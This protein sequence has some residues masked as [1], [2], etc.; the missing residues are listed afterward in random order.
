MSFVSGMASRHDDLRGFDM[1][2]TLGRTSTG[3]WTTEGAWE[4]IVF[5]AMMSRGMV[6]R[7]RLTNL[8]RGSLDKMAGIDWLLSRPDGTQTG[9]A[10]RT[11]WGTDYGTF[12]VR[13]RTE[14][15]SMSEATKRIMS[16][17]SGVGV[18]PGLTGQAYV[19]Q[20]DGVLLNAYLV[21]T[22]AMYEHIVLP[23]DTEDHFRLCGCCSQIKRAPGGALFFTVAI[24]EEG[25]VRSGSK[26]TLIASGVP[27]SHV[28][29]IN[30]GRGLWGSL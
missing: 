2:L 8:E 5:P 9:V 27:V 28:N 18:Y 12:T 29:P 22:K 4:Q 19:T 25:R 1:T 11:Q 26:T 30:E 13:Y 14:N 20:P 23:G 15:D 3:K 16:V 7:G 21:V 24:T 6:P 10:T 17:R